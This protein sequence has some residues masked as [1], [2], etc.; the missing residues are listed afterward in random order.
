[1]EDEVL[2]QVDP[3]C[4]KLHVIVKLQVDVEAVEYT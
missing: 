2:E 3:L 4:M 1:M